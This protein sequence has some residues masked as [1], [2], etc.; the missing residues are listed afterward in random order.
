MGP[1]EQQALRTSV[2]KA[3]HDAWSLLEF[4]TSPKTF[5]DD[6][7]VKPGCW[8]IHCQTFIT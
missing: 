5:S 1:D 4:N 6:A 8:Y 2:H 7:T 3:C